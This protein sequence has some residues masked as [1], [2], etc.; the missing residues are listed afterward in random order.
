MKA[1]HEVW[2]GRTITVIGTLFVFA[3]ASQQAHS[4]SQI[5]TMAVAHTQTMRLRN[6]LACPH[7]YKIWIALELQDGLIITRNTQVG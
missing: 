4:Q 1:I 2:L 5:A 7:Q 3:L 6:A